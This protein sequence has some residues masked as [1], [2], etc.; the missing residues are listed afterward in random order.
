MPRNIAIVFD[1][2]FSQQ[3]EK[4]A[5][6]APVWLVDT[7]QNRA[8]AETVNHAAVEWPHISVTIFRPLESTKEDW[9]SLLE[10]ITLRERTLE[11][12]DVIGAPLTLVARAALAESGLAR[13]D[14]TESG[15][16]ARRA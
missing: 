15:F 1:S 11:A 7:P 3:L 5:F 16:R 10:Q 4:L 13:F 8:A 9:R 12:V 6:R 14:E 2:D